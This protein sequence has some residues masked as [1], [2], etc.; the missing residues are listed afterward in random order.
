MSWDEEQRLN[1]FSPTEQPVMKA[2]TPSPPRS[3]ELNFAV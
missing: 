1:P 3:G 2:G